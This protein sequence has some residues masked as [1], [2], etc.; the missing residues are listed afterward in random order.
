[1]F[2]SDNNN[3][4]RIVFFDMHKPGL[5]KIT[6]YQA[7]I[8]SFLIMETPQNAPI[9]PLPGNRIIEGCLPNKPHTLPQ[10]RTLYLREF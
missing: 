4:F 2:Y 8:T 5:S 9:V 1:M 7:S 3:I 10:F 6:P